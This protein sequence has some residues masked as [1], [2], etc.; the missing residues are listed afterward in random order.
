MYALCNGPHSICAVCFSLYANKCTSYL[1]LCL[2]LNSFC[3]ETSR[4]WASLGP[5]TRYCGFWLGLSPS[6]VGSSP[7]QGFDWGRVPAHGFKSQ[8]EVNG[9]GTMFW[10]QVD[11]ENLEFPQNSTMELV[12]Q[13]LLLSAVFCTHQISSTLASHLGL[14]FLLACRTVCIFL[15]L[16]SKTSHNSTTPSLSCSLSRLPTKTHLTDIYSRCCHF[17]ILSPC[18]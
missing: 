7:K 8:S 17:V 15:T 6:H 2:S 10:H 16:A 13:L 5:K 11:K 18:L 1:S 9:F 14:W 3:D 4:T 12:Q